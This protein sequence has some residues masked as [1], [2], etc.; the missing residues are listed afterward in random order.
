MDWHK[1]ELSIGR[2]FDTCWPVPSG[3]WQCCWRGAMIAVAC[4]LLSGCMEAD[5][6]PRSGLELSKPD[7][8]LVGCEVVSATEER[9]R[10][11]GNGRE[12]PAIV[13]LPDGYKRR[14]HFPLVLAVHNFGGG[15]E[16]IAGMMEAER[17]RRA[18]N[19]VVVPEAAG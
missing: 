9:I 4:W 7:S 18:G 3:W 8:D 5:V 16:R 2:S 14:T 19:V 11:R 6:A 17:I 13:L 12:I 10:V 15:P 1:R